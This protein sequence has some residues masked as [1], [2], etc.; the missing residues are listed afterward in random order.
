[1]TDMTGLLKPEVFFSR[2][3]PVLKSSEKR[4]R[5]IFQAFNKTVRLNI[6]LTEDFLEWNRRRFENLYAGDGMMERYSAQQA[7]ATEWYKRA[8]R[9]AGD[10]QEVTLDLQSGT[11]DSFKPS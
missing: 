11:I 5:L 3:N 7:L 8:A 2:E 10:L 4:H 6:S 1:M 9:W